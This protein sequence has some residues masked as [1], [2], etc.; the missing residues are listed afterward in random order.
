MDGE[1]VEPRAR[2]PSD[3]GGAPSPSAQPSRA[4]GRRPPAVALVIGV[5]LLAVVAVAA[6]R[7]FATPE[8][9][10][11]RLV[12]LASSC[13]NGRVDSGEECDDG[14][15]RSDDGCRPDC[16]RARCGDGTVRAH[17]EE[18]DDGN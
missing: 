5:V 11:G 8:G 14:N 13:G 18:C 12:G 3:D 10:I 4:P 2:K 6:A 7:R 15:P 9:S 17:V 1:D 16:K